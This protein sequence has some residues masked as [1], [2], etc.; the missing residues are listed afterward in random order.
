MFEVVSIMSESGVV[1]YQRVMFPILDR[2]R[3]TQSLA[4]F[5]ELSKSQWLKPGEIIDLQKKRLKVLI[6]HA[7]DNVPYYKR[8]FR[9]RGL[10]PD[11][12]K[13]K[14]DLH[15]L[16]II[17][18]N[19]VRDHFDELKAA[20]F[21]TWKP[22]LRTT[23]GTTGKPLRYFSD[24]GEH[25][26]FWADLWRAW[27]W[28]GYELGDRRATIGGSRPP[29]Q[30]FSFGS[31]VRSRIMERSLSLSS[32]DVTP[33]AMAGHVE[34]LRDFKPKIVRGYPSSLYL[35]AKYMKKNA[36]S[37]LGI[38]SVIS[39]SE[40]LYDHQ[41]KAIEGAFG[42][43]VFDN[44][45][46]PDGGVVASECEDHE[47]HLNSENAIV[48]IVKDGDVLGFGEE[49]EIVST[50]LV[51]L[52]MPFIRYK[53]GDMAVASDEESR[54]GRGL[55]MLS[56][57]MGRTSGYFVLSDGALLA[58]VNL[59]AVFNEISSEIHIK[60][61]QVV[62]ES[63]GEATVLIVEDVGFD[64]SDRDLI[65]NSLYEHTQGKLAV[66]VRSVDDIPLT[67]AGKRRSFISKL[68]VGL[69]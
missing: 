43:P 45:G 20:N 5:A 13:T 21:R 42:C 52:A 22:I 25:S 19:T 26:V 40:Q 17:D 57:L 36:V 61:Y 35:F 69:E 49:G 44:Y 30:G 46:C 64:R 9:E 29:S 32:F 38:E 15:K 28:A 4:R 66:E 67:E 39:I 24:P 10:T 37:G 53:T 12:I 51:R 58:G 23:G 68:G 47:Y 7:Y 8:A 18:K 27:T 48:E 31:F 3:G 33:E 41:R 63:R 1:F 14:K 65:S 16:P 56:S 34:Q 50:N 59:A 60:Q 2:R 55:E 11:D 54:C 62:Q 6:K